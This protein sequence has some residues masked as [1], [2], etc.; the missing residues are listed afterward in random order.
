MNN[1]TGRKLL[2]ATDFSREELHDIIGLASQIKENPYNYTS[3]CSGRIMGSLFFEP[4]TRTKLSFDSAMK[5]LGG[6]VVGFSNPSATST[7]KGESVCDTVRTVSCYSDILVMRHPVKK[8]PHRISDKIH[9]PLINAGDG[10]N[11]HPTQT[12]T[13]LF[14]IHL[15]KKKMS[16][17]TIGL[18]GDLK[19]GRTIHSLIEALDRY[20]NNTFV[21][22]SCEQLKLPEEYKKKIKS[23]IIEVDNLELVMDKL[24]VVYMTRVQEE[25][26]DS[27][28]AY[29][30]VKDGCILTTKKLK[31]AKKDMIIMHPLPRVNEIEED[32]DDDHR[33]VYFQQAEAGM[34]IRM[35]LIM[36]L[37][38]LN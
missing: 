24:D 3:K 21:C 23:R 9:K 14:T 6:E 8:T 22:V 28:E 4:S 38:G 31:T 33:A 12:L 5:R 35:A 34:Y 32:V 17:L 11:Q 18:C 25:R 26:F 10:A 15:Y 19:Y 20:E 36:K 7:A 29:D 13:D 2:N 27:I 1:L 30:R 16:G 37:L